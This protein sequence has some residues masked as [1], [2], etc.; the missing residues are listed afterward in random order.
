[1]RRWWFWLAALAP[2]VLGLS[3]ALL[4]QSGRLPNPLL[5]LQADLGTILLLVGLL[6]S[7]A[8]VGVVA[9]WLRAQRRLRQ[10]VFEEREEAA[11]AHLRQGRVNIFCFQGLDGLVVADESCKRHPINVSAV[12][13]REKDV[14]P[15][16]TLV[17]SAGCSHLDVN[18]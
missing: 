4:L 8:A 6:F 7:G 1:M 18:T 2:A 12:L 5:D 10:V 9:L 15:I 3:L 13:R 11:E 17:G 16:Q 14:A